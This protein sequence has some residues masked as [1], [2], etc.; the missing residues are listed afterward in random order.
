MRMPPGTEFGERGHL[1]NQTE[2][3]SRC[4]SDERSGFLLELP[5]M[6]IRPCHQ[7]AYRWASPTLLVPLPILLEDFADPSCLAGLLLE[8]DLAF[9]ATCRYE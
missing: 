6:L 9:P 1:T 8:E 4:C 7:V 2:T 5:G 3:L